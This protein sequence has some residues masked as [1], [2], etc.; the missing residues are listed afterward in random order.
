MFTITSAIFATARWRA[1]AAAVTG[2]KSCL[3]A[4]LKN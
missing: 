4:E 3:A 2:V 1:D